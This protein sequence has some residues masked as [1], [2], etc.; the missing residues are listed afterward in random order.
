MNQKFKKIVEDIKALKIQGATNIAIKGLESLKYVKKENL[1]K[2]KKQLLSARPNEAMLSNLIDKA[3]SELQKGNDID[4]LILKIKKDK[5]KIFEIGAK[6]IK[7]NSIVFTHCHSSTVMGIIK[8]AKRKIKEVYCTESR[9]RYQ[10]RITAK[11]LT[12]AGIT[13]TMIVD[14]ALPN[15]LKKADYFLIGS[16]V[17][18]TTFLINKV[19]S[20]MISI[21][22]DKYDVPFYA[23]TLS[24]KFRPDTLKG[25]FEDVEQ[26]DPKEVW[27]TPPKKL[28]I[29][30]PAFDIVDFEAITGI[31][32]EKGILPPY[33]FVQ[34]MT[35]LINH[36]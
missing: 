23:C 24:Y 31:I 2:A 35:S 10:G 20:K 14:S 32:S 8:K 6:L 18:G 34:K 16:D 28:K 7:R 25:D 13:T 5:E 30:N 4:N 21:L 36:H 27:S 1:L 15:Y 19:G 9:P 26:R 12:D 29:L 22:C 11:E 17:V 33:A 3:I